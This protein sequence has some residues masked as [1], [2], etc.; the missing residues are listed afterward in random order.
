MHK[1]LARQTKRLFGIDATQLPVVLGELQRLAGLHG[2]SPEAASLLQGLEGFFSRVD[3]AYEQSDRD[4]DLKTRSL[5]LSSVELTHTNDRIRVELASRTR[6]IDS[7]RETAH[8]LMQTMGADVP[9]LQ[10]DNLESLSRLMSD[11]VQEREESQ[12]DL[13]SALTDLANQKFALDQHGIVSITD[14]TGRIL[15]ANDKFCEISG[16]PREQLLGQSHRIIKSDFHTDD[17]FRDMWRVISSGE[18]WHGE[19]CNRSRSGRLYWVQSTI[20]PLRDDMGVPTQFI[21]IRTDITERKLMEVTINAAEARLRHITNAVPGVVY[22]CEI[23][24]GRIRYTFVSD[25]LGEIRGLDR[26]ALLADGRLPALQIVSE[27]QRERYVQGVQLAAARQESW[28]GEYQIVLPN[29]TLRWIRGE[30]SPEP[31]LAADGST[32]FTG[33]WQDVTL[34]KQAGARLREITESIPVAVY[35]YHSSADGR[36]TMPFCSSAIER[37]CGIAPEELMLDVKT[38]FAQVH[39]DDRSSFF[40]AM[41]ASAESGEAWS[42]DF[43][44][45]HRVS[46]EPVWVHAA[47]QSKQ[48]LD[49]RRLWNGYLADISEAKRASEELRRAKEEA[50]AANRAKSDFLANMSHEI[51]TPMNGVIGMTE[52]AL[53]TDLTAEQREYME[54]VKSSSDSLLQVINDIL[55]F[56]KIEAGKLLIEKI[57]FNLGRTVGD[58]LKALAAQ[59]HAKG[60]ELTCDINAD[61]P[62]SLLGDS[63]RLRQILTNLI[64]NAIKFTE[65]G[66]VVLSV[67][68][69]EAG[70]L[71]QFTISDTG[72]GIPEAKLAA[73]FD[74]FSQEDSSITRKFGGTGLGLTI[75]SRLVEAL[76]GRL[77]VE[78][79]VGRGS[80]FHFSIRLEPD[81]E[82]GEMPRNALGLAGFRVLVVDDNAVNR[83]ILA[84]QLQQFGMQVQEFS[85]GETALAWL[86]AQGDQGHPCDLVL[87]DAQMPVLDGFATA[88]RIVTLPSCAGMPLIMLSSAGLKGDVQRSHEIGFSGY[89]SK[90]F[91]RDEL[92][93][94]L[95]RVMMVEPLSAAPLITRHTCHG[96]QVALK[97][98]LVEDHLVNQQLAI[99][100]LTRWGHQVSLACNGQLAL[101]TLAQHRFDLVLMDMM[102]PVMGGLEAT[103]C[104]R[105][106]EQGQRTPIVAMTANVMPGDR[107]SCIAAGMDDYISK[108]L[109]TAELQRLLRRYQPERGLTPVVKEGAPRIKEMIPPHF[110][111]DLAL[112]QADQE[113]VDIIADV[114]LDQWPLDKQKME[115]ALRDNDMLPILHLTHALKGTLAMFGA[116]PPAEMAQR[117]EQ[118]A[119][120][121]EWAG[122]AELIGSITAEVAKLLVAL[123]RPR[124]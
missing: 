104:F 45:L 121:G 31:E 111:Y 57:P 30:I 18:V 76:G 112:A 81:V 58:T 106:R 118:L 86:V 26:E 97:I 55:D 82:T 120:Q 43:R 13:Q 39:P 7:L 80:R 12:K 103:R 63:G 75:S 25:R 22:Q 56:S 24:Q 28:S 98:L 88:E 14:V 16:Y 105:A 124:V 38:L 72:I 114:F 109:E 64:G 108:P 91:T 122:L 33:I 61:V 51:R 49:G 32:V 53:D 84:R 102:M 1:L 21:A 95:L 62:M 89:L 8:S 73:I 66:E 79:E 83:M 74:A 47:A 65:Q 60:L 115:Q 87:L 59:A 48:A 77:W 19:I 36:Q 34:L 4:L 29:G 9:A 117:A 10:D 123:Q 68:P 100:L 99:K 85:S 101:D 107:E 93:Q 116:R 42:V 90:P 67:R 6:A 113:V 2:M 35:Q 92:L 41:T 78:S 40:A 20:V 71:I 3:G 119:A 46:G 15:Y 94:V 96:E 70:S 54:I 17:F 23:G 50:E 11:L 52:L 5:Q 44:L 110:D 37:I 69:A 27:E